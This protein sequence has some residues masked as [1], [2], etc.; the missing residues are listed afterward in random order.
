MR[1]YFFDLGDLGALSA[2]FL[3]DALVLVDW[4]VGEMELLAVSRGLTMGRANIAVV[5]RWSS[6]CFL[7]AC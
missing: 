6:L 3:D 2:D 1:G 7:M 4:F 5:G